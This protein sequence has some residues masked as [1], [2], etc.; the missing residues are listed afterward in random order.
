MDVVIKELRAVNEPVPIPLELPDM[1]AIVEV[2][3]QILVSLDREFRR[4]LLTVSDVVYGTLEPVTVADPHAHTYLP[5]VA[6]TAWSLGVPRRL[7][8]VCETRG[9]YYCANAL[10]EIV[11]WRDGRLVD[12]EPWEDIWHWAR[13]VWLCS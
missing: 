13:D 9:D 1:D 7:V 10:G 3:E 4:F 5:E 11:L 8:P 12:D 6:A 2:E